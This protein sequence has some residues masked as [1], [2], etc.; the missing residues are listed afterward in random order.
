ME[1]KLSEQKCPACGAPLRFDPASGKSVCDWCGTSYEIPNEADDIPEGQQG[2]AQTDTDELPIYNCRSCGAE[3]VTDA[4]SASVTCPYCGNNIVLTEK[5][6]GGLRPD[7]IIPFRID[8]KQLP[9]AVAQFDKG[10]KLL[11]RRYFTESSI[12]DLCGVYVPFWLYDCNY[13]GSVSFDGTKSSAVRDGDYIVTTQA[14]YD[15]ERAI[16]LSFNDIPVDGSARLDDALMDSLEP[17]DMSGVKPFNMSYLSGFFAER[18][19]KDSDEVRQRAETRMRTSAMSIVNANAAAGES[20]SSLTL[21]DDDLH[22]DN[23]N[24]KYYLLPVYTFG[25]S[26]G[27][28]KYTFAMNGQTG[29]VVGEV[30]TDK[31]KS[32][33]NRWGVFAAIFAVLMLVLWFVNC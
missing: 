20:Y 5:V 13:R 8:K 6:S 4:V 10:R 21:R 33:L 32:L 14:H 30:P 12:E 7:G 18:F 15:V 17:F 31:G 2:A 27:D 11:P 16:D 23:V 3:I 19:D 24:A 25:V 28:R 29:K 22:A 1:Q 26:Y 9:E